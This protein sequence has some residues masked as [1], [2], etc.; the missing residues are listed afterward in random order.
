MPF[1]LFT[2]EIKNA[3]KY[4]TVDN[5]QHVID[6]MPTIGLNIPFEIVEI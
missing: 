6:T 5:A 3:M 1:D 4:E 2:K